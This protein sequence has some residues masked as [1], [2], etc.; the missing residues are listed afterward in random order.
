M[1]NKQY[2]LKII[3][4]QAVPAKNYLLI[5]IQQ[6]ENGEVIYD[7]FTISHI[8]ERFFQITEKNAFNTILSGEKRL[9]KG[10]VQ[11]DF[12]FL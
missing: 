4:Q 1:G 5:I 11:N 6:Q 7:I 10:N 8:L 9:Q 3:G 2:L 12:N